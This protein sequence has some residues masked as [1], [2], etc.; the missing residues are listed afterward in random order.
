M[1]KI[2]SLTGIIEANK[3]VPYRETNILICYIGTEPV[4]KFKVHPQFVDNIFEDLFVHGKSD[5]RHY[6]DESMDVK[7]L[8]DEQKA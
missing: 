6:E 7:L 2:R 1:L 5:V 8:N 4:H 3:V